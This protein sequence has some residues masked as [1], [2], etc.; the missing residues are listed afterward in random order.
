M[1]NYKNNMIPQVY[2]NTTKE[3]EFDLRLPQVKCS[4]LQ[5]NNRLKKYK[6]NMI[7][8]IHTNTT[9]E[10]ELDLRLPQVKC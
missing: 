10:Y 7:P 9:E 5:T 8:K 3:N 4:K 1:K 2:K 6:N